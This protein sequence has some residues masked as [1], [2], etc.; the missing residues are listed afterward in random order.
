M[1]QTLHHW[2]QSKHEADTT[3]K[4]FQPLKTEPSQ[5]FTLMICLE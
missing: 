4:V 2:Q 3:V 1:D 5:N